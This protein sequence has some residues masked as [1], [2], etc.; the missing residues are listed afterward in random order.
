MSYRHGRDRY[1]RFRGYFVKLR[2]GEMVAIDCGWDRKRKCRNVKEFMFIKVTR[3][4]FNFLDLETGRTICPTH[5]FYMKGMGGK[6]FPE[7][8][9]IEG[10]FFIP[11]YIQIHKHYEK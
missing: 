1:P 7:A 8:V 6:D 3:K 2:V 10:I 5:H 9:S 11:E 4:G